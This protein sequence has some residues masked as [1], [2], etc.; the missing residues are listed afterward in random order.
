MQKQHWI[1]LVI[2]FTLLTPASVWANASVI[3]DSL[4]IHRDTIENHIQALPDSL[5]TDTPNDTLPAATNQDTIPIDTIPIDTIPIDT[6][7]AADSINIINIH[8]TDSLLT[9]DTIPVVPIDIIET[10][11]V[12]DIEV[13]SLTPE[14]TIPVRQMAKKFKEEHVYTVTFDSILLSPPKP[15]EVFAGNEVF[16][17][18]LLATND[19]IPK[20]KEQ[21]SYNWPIVLLFIAA[22]M[23]GLARYFQPVGI[24]QTLKASYNNQ[25]FFQLLKEQNPL[26]EWFS[27]FM[28]VGYF[29]VFSI[30]VF[31]SLLTFEMISIDSANHG[32]TIF[33]TIYLA[34]LL[35]YLAKYMGLKL[36]G[37]VFKAYN[38]NSLYFKNL[39][40]INQII[41]IIVMP[42]VLISLIYNNPA[43]LVITWVV[44]L[45]ISLFKVFRSIL[46]GHST[47]NFSLYYLFLYLCAVEILPLILIIKASANYFTALD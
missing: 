24:R 31:Q 45:V 10:E 19:L 44:F 38:A 43:F 14:P 34:V 27:F 20:R 15:P 29:A 13:P 5:I 26:N 33:L 6:I 12:S 47:A 3:R 2:L 4:Q 9:I 37:F 18:N 36:I 7:P 23:I 25:N 21:T 1:Y 35:F 40:L 41:G 30:L 11:D 28:S 16:N 22:G 8:R 39:M 17:E 42:L 32:L 46:I